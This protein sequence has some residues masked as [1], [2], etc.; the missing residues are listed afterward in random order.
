MVITD[1]QNTLLLLWFIIFIEKKK[2]TIMCMCAD[3]GLTAL[4]ETEKKDYHIYSEWREKDQSSSGAESWDT[5]SVNAETVFLSF[6]VVLSNEEINSSSH[7]P[8]KTNRRK[9]P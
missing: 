3:E 9:E 4:N 8:N 5:E 2:Q 7:K 6:Q 1:Y